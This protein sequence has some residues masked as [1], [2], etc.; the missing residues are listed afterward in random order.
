MSPGTPVAIES[1]VDRLWGEDPP[2]KAREDLRVYVSRLNRSLRQASG[3]E[4]RID[5]Q[6]HGYAL[7]VDPQT[8]DLHRFR[9]LRRQA[10]AM[11]LSGDDEQAVTLLRTAE[12]LWRGGQALAG[13]P[14]EWVARLRA[15]LEEE[16]RAVIAQRIE[17][18]LRLGRHGMLAGELHRLTDEYP[19]DEKLIGHQMTALYR[20]GRQADALRVYREARDRLIDEGVEPVP[21]LAALQQA[22]LRHDPE[23][24]LTPVFHPGQERQPD[25]LPPDIDGFVGRTDELRHIDEKSEH[26]NGP[27]IQLIEGMPGVG[28]TALAIRAAHLLAGRYPNAQLFLNFHTHDPTQV[29][30]RPA[31]AVY[32]L[33]RMLDVPTN[34]IPTGVREQAEVWQAELA[35]R[36]LIIVLDDVRDLEEIRP[37]L[38]RTGDSLTIVTSR[39]RHWRHDGI[40]SL[41]LRALPVNDAITLFTLVGGQASDADQVTRAVKL[42]GCLPLAIRVTASRLRHGKLSGLTELLDELSTR[43]E[44]PSFAGPVSR[45]IMPVFDASYHGLSTSQRRLFRYLGISPCADTSIHAAMALTGK[46]LS[47]TQA[48]IRALVDHHLLTESS[49]GR[50]QFHDVTHSYAAA[51]SARDDPESDQRAAIASLLSYYLHTVRKASAITG[52]RKDEDSPPADSVGYA[53]PAMDTADAARKWLESEW[54]NILLAAGYA[55]GHEWK[56]QCAD[57]TDALAEFLEVS[58]HWDAAIEAHALALQACRD[59]DDAPRAAR[60]VC[61]LSLANLRAGRQEE[62]LQHATE[63]AGLFRRLGDRRG[64]AAAL[65]RI[66]IV[67]RLSARFRDSLAHHQESTEIYQAIGDLHGM[68]RALCHTGSAYSSLGRYREGTKC[69][70]QALALCR[71]IGNKRY[72][73]IALNNIGAVQQEQGY[74]RDAVSN[75]QESFRIFEEI[76]GQPNMAISYHNMAHIHQYKGD[77][78]KAL[79]TYRRVLSIYRSIGDLRDQAHVFC[80]IALVYEDKGHHDEALAHHEKAASTAQEIGDRYLCAKALCGMADTHRGSGRHQSALEVYQK[81]LKLAREIEA[82]LMEAK[83]LQGMG[84]TLLPMQGPETA[85]IYW[86]QALDLY[87]QM[88]VLEATNMEIRLDTL[89]ESA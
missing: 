72:E 48:A 58:G 88:G 69:L 52:I 16:R 11:A 82:P 23:L 64:E 31:D 37:L 17:L 49:P 42:C 79:A 30:V 83:A 10:D 89:G 14:G 38:P 77:H 20:S 73:A 46:K 32:G 21:A 9:L 5:A 62:A 28:K 56:R 39:R 53:T 65:D 2:A 74:H 66:G 71:Q 7:L 45:D 51:R 55:A 26:G 63:A 43:D 24:T 25:T 41:T 68:A 78:E 70:N 19:L 22:I 1:L 33:L 76:D 57:L 27:L 86:R 47:A 34:R 50:F 44:Q 29:P 35:R 4:A 84:D 3:G 8:V 81:A 60:A 18:E 40:R 85:R 75:Y 67:H 12:A 87:Q 59:L 36:R 80:D 13:L 6:A 54:R 15:I 61:E